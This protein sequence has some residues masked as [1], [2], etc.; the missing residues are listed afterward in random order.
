MPDD[1]KRMALAG[2]AVLMGVDD[3]LFSIPGTHVVE[4]TI[5]D[6]PEWA[7][8]VIPIWFLTVEASTLCAVSPAYRTVADK[9]IAQLTGHTLLSPQLAHVVATPGAIGEWTQREIF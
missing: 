6:F 1:P 4:T 8:W 9:I 7:N 5:R 2:Y 3:R